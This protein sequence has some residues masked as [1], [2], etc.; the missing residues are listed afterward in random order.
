MKVKKLPVRILD[1]PVLA[2][3]IISA[4]LSLKNT[5]KSTGNK[6]VIEANGTRF[7]YS[8]NQDG[9]YSVEG[10]I[11]YTTFEIKNGGV[12]II[13]SPCPNKTC[14]EQGWSNPLICLPNKVS[15]NVEGYGEFDAVTE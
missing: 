9:I 1:L 2:I 10:L 11:G 15:I 3:V 4:I 13:D 5:A 8:L 6:A 12:H 7:E 14:I